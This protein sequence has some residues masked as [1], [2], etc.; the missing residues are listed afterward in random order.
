MWIKDSV[1]D[2]VP[3]KRG[4][5]VNL[6]FSYNVLKTCLS[7]VKI[8]QLYI[9]RSQIS[10]IDC[11]VRRMRVEVVFGNRLSSCITRFGRVFSAWTE[12]RLILSMEF[13]IYSSTKKLRVVKH[14]HNFG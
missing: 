13:A 14:A 10:N 2:S 11:V 9:N 7:P 12:R 3:Q 5:S 4:T 6:H 8:K 1:I